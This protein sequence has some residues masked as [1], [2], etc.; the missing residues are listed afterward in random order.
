MDIGEEGKGGK[1]RRLILAGFEVNSASGFRRYDVD[2][3]PPP[4]HGITV[5]ASKETLRNDFEELIGLQVGAPE[6]LTHTHQHLR[7]RPRNEEITRFGKATQKICP[8]NIRLIL[9]VE[10]ANNGLGEKRAK[11]MLIQKSADKI[12]EGVRR[13][14]P[15]FS[16]L[17]ELCAKVNKLV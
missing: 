2:D 10:A 5:E 4:A 12:G 13:Y 7:R 14:L 15:S 3:R 16:H 17:I 1:Q 11:T 9:I 8:T 6:R